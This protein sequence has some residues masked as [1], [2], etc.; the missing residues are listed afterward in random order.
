MTPHGADA[1]LRRAMQQDQAAIAQRLAVGST[2]QGRKDP[3]W[4]ACAIGASFVVAGT[5]TK[6]VSRTAA[7]YKRWHGLA[8]RTRQEGG[9]VVVER[10]K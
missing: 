8:F 10:V 2:G 7:Y 5:V 3:R 1:A 4:R 6:Y 9:D